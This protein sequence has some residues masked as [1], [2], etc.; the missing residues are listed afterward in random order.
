MNLTNEN[1][2]TMSRQEF[3]LDL[4]VV[5][6]NSFIYETLYITLIQRKFAFVCFTSLTQL[7][8]DIKQVMNH[9]YLPHR[10]NVIEIFFIM[11]YQQ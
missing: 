5:Q 11:T 9:L 4:I 1:C 10:N 6:H 7:K 8:F 3:Y 2:A